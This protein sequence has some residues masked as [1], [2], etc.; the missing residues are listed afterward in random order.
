MA[1]KSFH[2]LFAPVE[3]VST[4]NLLRI[5]QN[6]CTLKLTRIYYSNIFKSFYFLIIFF[7]LLCI[8]STIFQFYD[9]SSVMLAVEA[10]IT[11]LLLFEMVYRVLMQGFKDY[12][13]QW[14]N[15]VDVLIII[16]SVVLLWVG[17]ELGGGVGEIDAV[18][19]VFLIITR[20]LVQFL[21][22][23]SSLR[24]K[25]GQDVQIIDLND[26][27]GEDAG[28]K[29]DKKKAK[30]IPTTEEN[31]YEEQKNEYHESQADGL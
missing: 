10:F 4:N 20:S 16:A 2:G 7:S 19:G 18:T 1:N 17:V 29:D 14:W 31:K 27:S 25:K 28:M 8:F 23:A 30:H 5:E 12:I 11:F 15:V 6:Q 9:R 22:L 24:K 21:R 26:I 13:G 3:V